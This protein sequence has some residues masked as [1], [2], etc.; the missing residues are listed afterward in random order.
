MKVES[1]CRRLARFQALEP[2]AVYPKEFWKN[3]K[4]F[5]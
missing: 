2:P 1:S 5:A 3:P 4:E